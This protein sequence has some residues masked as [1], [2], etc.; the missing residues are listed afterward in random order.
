VKNWFPEKP[1]LIKKPFSCTIIQLFDVVEVIAG[2]H[3][4]TIET[5]GKSGHHGKWYPLTAGARHLNL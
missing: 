5:R 4:L 3:R 2:F 1:T